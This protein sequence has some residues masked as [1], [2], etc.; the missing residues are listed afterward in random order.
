MRFVYSVLFLSVATSAQAGC[1]IPLPDAGLAAQAALLA[2][3]GAV[4]GVK[5]LLARKS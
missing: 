1:I 3:V 5:F 4:G 2:A